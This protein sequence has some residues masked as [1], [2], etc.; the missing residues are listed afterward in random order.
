MAALADPE[1]DVREQ[2]AW[3]L[4]MIED[5]SAATAIADALDREAEPEV[6]RQL[7]WALTR[8]MDEPGVD[9]EPSE[10]A[11]ILRRALGA[12]GQALR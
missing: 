2:V 11:D 8:V 4:G 6:R 12:R 5:G 1:P 7:V 3:A 10:L 9:L